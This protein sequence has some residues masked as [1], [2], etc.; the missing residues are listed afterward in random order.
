MRKSF[1]ASIL[2]VVFLSTLTY[3]QDKRLTM[4]GIV[5]DSDGAS[6]E[7]MEQALISQVARPANLT[8][9]ELDRILF[10]NYDKILADIG[11]AAG[12]R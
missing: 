7:D 11:L 12:H 6:Y 2:A 10:R 4:S 5:T 9:A 1:S 8:G 3:A